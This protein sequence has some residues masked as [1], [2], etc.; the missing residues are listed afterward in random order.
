M[1]ESLSFA[2]TVPDARLPEQRTGHIEAA[3]PAGQL[4]ATLLSVACG[5]GVVG[6]VRGGWKAGLQLIELNLIDVAMPPN[7]EKGSDADAADVV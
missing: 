7:A 6:I 3:A 1:E 5:G 4:E 2:K